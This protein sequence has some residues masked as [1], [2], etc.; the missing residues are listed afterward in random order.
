MCDWFGYGLG[1]IGNPQRVTF[2]AAIF[3]AT[4]E[5]VGLESNIERLGNFS[6]LSVGCDCKL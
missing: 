5:G 4:F 1:G 2:R 3:E 6:M